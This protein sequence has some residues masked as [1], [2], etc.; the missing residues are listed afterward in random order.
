MENRCRSISGLGLLD[1]DTQFS[2]KKATSQVEAEELQNANGPQERLLGYEI[3]MGRTKRSGERNLFKIVKKSGKRY[4][5]YDGAVSADGKVWGTYIHGIFDNDGFRK[6]FVSQ[7]TGRDNPGS[8]DGRSLEFS[9]FKDRQLDA[10]A[11]LV[12]KSLNMEYIANL[13]C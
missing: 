13:I 7:N 11:E 1:V 5:R 3:H 4:V 9:D 2:K 8:Y 10:L 6:R 12:K